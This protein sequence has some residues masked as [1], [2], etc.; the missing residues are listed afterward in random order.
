MTK[1]SKYTK[2]CKICQFDQNLAKCVNMGQMCQNMTSTCAQICETLPKNAL[3][4]GK[5]KTHQDH[6]KGMEKDVRSANITT[7]RNRRIPPTTNKQK[8]IF[9][10]IS[11]K[12]T[13]KKKRKIKQVKVKAILPLGEIAG[14]PTT[15]RGF[16]HQPKKRKSKKEK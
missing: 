11:R 10:F 13:V 1:W 15:K 5:V 3:I 6:G 2:M 16:S 9:S 8:R 12:G 4:C 7:R 14:Y